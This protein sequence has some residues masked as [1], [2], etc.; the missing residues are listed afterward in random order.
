MTTPVQMVVDHKKHKHKTMKRVIGISMMVMFL[1]CIIA[2][3]YLINH[4]FSNPII[5]K[6]RFQFYG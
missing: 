1:F 3:L 2:L 6:Y 5:P 4:R